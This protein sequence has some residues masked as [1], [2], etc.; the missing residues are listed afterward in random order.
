M[1]QEVS[2]RPLTSKVR[3]SGSEICGGQSGIGT[4]FLPVL[5]FF[6]R[7]YHSTNAPYS[8]LRTRFSDQ[9][10]KWAKPGILTKSSVLSEIGEN[11]LDNIFACFLI[12]KELNG[13]LSMLVLRVCWAGSHV[14]NETS[15]RPIDMLKEKFHKSHLLALLYA[16]RLWHITALEGWHEITTSL[17]TLAMNLKSYFE[18]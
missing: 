8:S 1:D 17:N 16:E 4:G 2:S 18:T 10:G 6:P 11:S 13:P 5:R 14:C 9:K 15:I 3:S 7:Q 12:F